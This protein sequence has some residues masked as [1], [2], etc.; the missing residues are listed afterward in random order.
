[1]ATQEQITFKQIRYFQGDC[2]GGQFPTCR[3][4]GWV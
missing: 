2:R 1:M 4:I 3:L